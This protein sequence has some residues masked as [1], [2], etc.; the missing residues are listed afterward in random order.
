MHRWYQEIDN[1]G[2]VESRVQWIEVLHF[3]TCLPTAD[4][5]LR[6]GSTCTEGLARLKLGE[7]VNPL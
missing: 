4:S 3:Y 1:E 7:T 5:S 6:G 2:E